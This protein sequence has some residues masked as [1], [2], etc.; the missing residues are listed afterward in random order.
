MINAL[1][2]PGI[3]QYFPLFLQARARQIRV[4]GTDMFPLEGRLSYG[5]SIWPAEL[6]TL[7]SPAPLENQAWLFATTADL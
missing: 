2:S 1:I 7:A 5:T 4:L 3:A 6:Q